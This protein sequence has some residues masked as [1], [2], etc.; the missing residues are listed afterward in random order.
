MESDTLNIRDLKSI[1]LVF[2]GWLRYLA[3]VDD[4][5]Q[6]FQLSPDPLLDMLQDRISGLH[7]GK[8]LGAEEEERLKTLLEDDKI[9]GV[10]LY[11]AGM[12]EEVIEYYKE[13]MEGPGAVRGVLKKMRQHMDMR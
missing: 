1:P 12:A 4:C 9:F 6:P 11:E 13:M 7:L 3:G 8:R 2:A 5:G 10:N